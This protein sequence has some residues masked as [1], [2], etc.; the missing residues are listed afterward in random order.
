ME[1]GRKPQAKGHNAPARYF[2]FTVLLRFLTEGSTGGTP[3]TRSTSELF[4]TLFLRQGLR[5]KLYYQRRAGVYFPSAVNLR[6]RS[7]SLSLSSVF[8]YLSYLAVCPC[9]ANVVAGHPLCWLQLVRMGCSFVCSVCSV[10]FFSSVWCRGVGLL[11]AYS[12]QSS[13]VVVP[14]S[15]VIEK[16]ILC[17]VFF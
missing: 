3:P 4:L 6:A 16:A 12:K 15:C 2:L 17:R 13:P 10:L 11:R 14:I 9:R 8:P 7:V 5:A 1:K